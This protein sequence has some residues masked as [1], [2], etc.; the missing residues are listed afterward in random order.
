MVELLCGA[1]TLAP[2]GSG[3]ARGRQT[4]RM[5]R[6]LQDSAG[7]H[8]PGG[9]TRTEQSLGTNTLE[10]AA[11]RSLMTGAGLVAGAILFSAC[12]SDVPPSRLPVYVGPL[13]LTREAAVP[14]LPDRPFRAGLVFIVDRSAPDA[15]PPPP[16]EALNRIKEEIESQL[17]SFLGIIIE[18]EIPADG[19][20]PGG[21][22]AQFSE[23]GRKHGVDYLVLV[24]FSS[25][26]VEYPIYVF[27]GWTS[28][29]QPGFR[30][31]NW[32]LFEVALL[33]VK[34]GRALVQAEGRGWATLDSPTAPGIN[35]WYP[36]V[37]LRQQGLETARRYWPPT[38]AASRNTLRVVS[39]KDTAKH[40]LGKLQ[41]A[42]NEKRQAELT[43][44]G[45]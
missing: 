42:W 18:K 1:V 44:A 25:T 4:T 20:K 37:Y 5:T 6:G 12:A 27:L 39:M 26:E 28:H 29:M 21:E 19:I 14:A 32:S 8:R 43:A 35:Q 36:V 17:E 22:A 23:L 10:K 24:V 40:L 15:A 11:M 30:L 41:D 16:D 13:S 34:T 38:F 33:D 2:G 9:L 3:S 45:P 31:D 7:R